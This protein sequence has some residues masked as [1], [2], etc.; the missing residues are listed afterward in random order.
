LYVYVLAFW[1]VALLNEHN[2]G[3]AV[4]KDKGTKRQFFRSLDW[5]SAAAKS[6]L[7]HW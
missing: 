2:Y 1:Q 5:F 3:D 7:C 4:I 6:W